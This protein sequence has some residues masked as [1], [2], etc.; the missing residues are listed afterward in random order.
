MKKIIL[1]LAVLSGCLF[2]SD[3]LNID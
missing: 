1:I 2:S 3:E